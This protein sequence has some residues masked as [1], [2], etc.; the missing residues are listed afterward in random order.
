MTVNRRDK[1]NEIFEKARQR[2]AG[3]QHGFIRDQCGDD[4]E[5]YAAAVQ[6]LDHEGGHPQ[7]LPAPKPVFADGT[8]VAGRYRII[9]FLNRGGMGEVYEA[10]DLEMRERVALKTLLPSIAADGR[11]IARFKQEIQLSRQVSHENVYRVFDLARHQVEGLTGDAQYFLTM[12]LLSGE[13]LAQ[14][15][16]GGRRMSCEDALPLLEQMAAGLDAAHRVGVIHR[17]FKPSNVMLAKCLGGTRVVVTDFGLSRRSIPDGDTTLTLSGAIMGTVDYMAP[18]LFQGATATIASDIYALATV[19]YRMITGRLPF[20]SK[21]PEWRQAV[22]SPRKYVPELDAKWERAILRGMDREPARRF[23]TAGRFVSALKEEATGLTVPLPVMTRRRWTAAAGVLLLALAAFWVLY[24]WRATRNQSSPEARRWYELGA[25]ALRDGTYYRAARA[26]A[27]AIAIDPGFA[28]AHARLAEARNELDDSERAKGEMLVALDSPSPRGSPRGAEILYVDAIHRTLTGD[29]AGAIRVYLQ[30]EER[31]PD[32]DKTAVLVDL[33][34]AYQANEQPQEALDAYR[35]AIRRDSQN[36]A[37]HLR[38]GILLGRLGKYIEANTELEAAGSLY[39]ASSNNE[40]QVEVL[41]Q[42]ALVATASLNFSQATAAVD[43]AIELSKAI[44]TEHQQIAAMLQLGVITYL[45]GSPD[46]AA[47]IAAE[48]TSKARLAGMTNLAARGLTDLGSAEFVK[49]DLTRAEEDFRDALELARHYG[50]R[51]YEARALLSLASLHQQKGDSESTLREARSALEFYQKAGF[52]TQTR[53][54]LILIARTYRDSGMEGEA[55]SAFEQLL[56]SATTAS[57]RVQMAQAEQG[58][59]S[60]LLQKE[61]WTESLDHYQHCYS[62]AKEI[63]YVDMVTRSL[64]GQGGVL[65]RLGRYAEAEQALASAEAAVGRSADANQIASIAAERR[66]SMLLSR[67]LY[68]ESAAS[69]K[70]AAT[71]VTAANSSPSGSQCVGGVAMAQSR[72]A[73]EGERLCRSGLAA[74]ESR[75]DRSEIAALRLLLAQILLVGGQNAEA[76][77]QAR[78]AAEESDKAGHPES[79]WRGWAIVAIASR[80]SGNPAHAQA[81]DRALARLAGLRDLWGAANYLTYLARPDI[82]KLQANLPTP[83]R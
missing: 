55:L 64:L 48:A 22:P 50:A 45:E 28:L 3:E 79:A 25:A 19:A 34:R 63:G 20:S 15:L 72:A 12:E 36:A 26:L 24:G 38:A 27:Q 23:A 61:R 67:G 29:S 83:A 35:V 4:A 75:G 7:D 37:A 42:R 71:L 51:R 78:T 77:E 39:Q 54:C 14:R 33:G 56:S 66:A 1:L 6:M 9:A 18:E 60:V 43:K 70:R 65:W 40:G 52:P 8:L 32:A 68:R 58:I 59:A 49:R 21:D 10:E 53:Q 46:E 44:S 82:R 81:A 69:A 2:P 17:D 5:L 41:Y 31:V 47:R 62:I 11:M 73:A 30:L 80:P 76:A 57:D 74:A 13:T 16:S